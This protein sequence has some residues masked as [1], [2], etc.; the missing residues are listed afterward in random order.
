MT[1]VCVFLLVHLKPRLIFTNTRPIVGDM[2]VHN[3]LVGFVTEHFWDH[4][5]M[6]GWSMQWSA[7]FPAYRFY[8]SLPALFVAMLDV[9]FPAAIALKLAAAIPLVLVPIAVY[10]MCARFGLEPIQRV[11]AAAASLLFLFDSSQTSFGGNIGSTVTGEFPFAWGLVMV[12]FS[13]GVMATDFQ[14]RRLLPGAVVLLA[15]A[16][17]CHPIAGV[18]ALI[19]VLAMACVQPP[20]QWRSTI[21]TSAVIV[22]VAGA[23]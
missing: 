6:S 1:A 20:T 21:R 12:V 4:G 5:L 2:I 10:A 14:R 7:G 9:L 23:P 13:L 17:L 16:L 15:V 19:G 8:I 18:V 3:G 11:L 22:G